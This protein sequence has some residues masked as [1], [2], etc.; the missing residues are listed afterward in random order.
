MTD[1]AKQIAG[2]EELEFQLHVRYRKNAIYIQALLDGE[3]LK[4][5]TDLQKQYISVL[6]TFVETEKNKSWYDLELCT[7]E[8]IRLVDLIKNESQ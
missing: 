8:I 7:D 1:F 6:K 3:T 5:E 4:D 2:I